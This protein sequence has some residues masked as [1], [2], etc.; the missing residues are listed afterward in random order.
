MILY[1]DTSSLV[2]LY[3]EEEKCRQ[4]RE[5]ARN[6]EVVATCRIAYAE[7]LSAFA[8][9]RAAGNFSASDFGSVRERFEADWQDFAA[10][11]FDERRAG[12]LAVKHLLR[13][14]DAVHLSSAIVLREERRSADVLVVFSAF[15]AA[16]RKAAEKEGFPIEPP[17]C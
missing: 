8:R 1:L 13:G 4:V 6:A 10:L 14:F 5:W 15:D 2:K 17:A 3:V 9:R 7:T 16:L 12:D 11:D